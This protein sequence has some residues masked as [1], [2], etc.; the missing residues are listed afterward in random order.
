M[1]IV[2]NTEVPERIQE[3]FSKAIEIV[4]QYVKPERATVIFCRGSFPVTFTP[5]H[6]GIYVKNLIAFDLSKLETKD[7]KMIMAAFLEEFAHC[8]LDIEDEK[9]VGYKVAE[10]YSEVGFDGKKYFI[11]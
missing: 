4:S 5:E 8:L 3:L 9:E 10:I 2:L 11:K 6:V 7:N 1:K